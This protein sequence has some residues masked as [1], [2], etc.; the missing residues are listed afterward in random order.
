MWDKL[1]LAQENRMTA[2]P[3]GFVALTDHLIKD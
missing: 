1:L 2:W 3:L